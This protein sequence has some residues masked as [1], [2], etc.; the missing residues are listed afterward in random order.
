MQ[1]SSEFKVTKNNQYL[2][3]ISVGS[4]IA[5]YPWYQWQPP[6]LSPVAAIRDLPQQ[7]AASRSIRGEEPTSH[8][9]QYIYHQHHGR[10]ELLH[11]KRE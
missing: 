4:S 1:H 9:I 7:Q 8:L 6:S 3:Q 11:I 10:V 5:P 2:L